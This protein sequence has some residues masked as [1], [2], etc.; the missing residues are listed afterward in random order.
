MSHFDFVTKT[1]FFSLAPHVIRKKTASL[2]FPKGA[3]KEKYNNILLLTYKQQQL[4]NLCVLLKQ[5][6]FQSVTENKTPG[7][8]ESGFFLSLNNTFIFK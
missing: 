3:Q 1:E 6:D 2:L 4:L 8:N 5:K 7:S